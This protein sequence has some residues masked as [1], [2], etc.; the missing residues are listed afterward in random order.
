MPATGRFRRDGGGRRRGGR[1]GDG[2]R[3][4]GGFAV[5]ERLHFRTLDSSPR[6]FGQREVCTLA[7]PCNR[8][9]RRPAGSRHTL[10]ENRAELP[11]T[12]RMASGAKGH[13]DRRPRRGRGRSRAQR[14]L[15]DARALGTTRTTAV[16][17]CSSPATPKRERAPNPIPNNAV[18]PASAIG[19][20]RK[21]LSASWK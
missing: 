18:F 4:R 6:R 15:T 11:A 17:F 14:S 16:S 3:R 13:R 2:L 19:R 5:G 8:K 9:F 12:R 21:Q 20:D 1:R 10:P 7:G